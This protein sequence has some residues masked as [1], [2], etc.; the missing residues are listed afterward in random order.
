MRRESEEG[1]WRNGMSE[2]R[3]LATKENQPP[4]YPSLALQES[5]FKM[6]PY[7]SFYQQNQFRDQILGVQIRLNGSSLYIYSYKPQEVQRR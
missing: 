2:G 3:E 1:G 5:T 4:L 7:N 6:D